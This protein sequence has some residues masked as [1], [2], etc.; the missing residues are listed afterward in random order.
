MFCS[1]SILPVNKKWHIISSAWWKK[2][3]R[4]FCAGKADTPIFRWKIPTR[5]FFAGKS[6]HVDFPLRKPT[7]RFLVEKADTSILVEKG[8]TSGLSL[9]YYY[10]SW[11]PL[12][13]DNHLA[14]SA[15]YLYVFSDIISSI[16]HLSNW[17]FLI[18]NKFQ[19]RRVRFF[20]QKSTCRLS[21]WKIDGS[22]FP[23]K[24]RRIGFSSGKS[25]S[26]FSTKPTI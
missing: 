6:R 12:T 21:Q 13:L 15:L 20:N 2:P 14:R 24:N 7:R 1:S 18:E 3:T 10:L 25:T 9:N 26:A 5:R 17:S 11:D 23:A 22:A 8:H 4:R 19:A 16:I